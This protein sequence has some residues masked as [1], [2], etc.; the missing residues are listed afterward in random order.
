MTGGLARVLLDTHAFLWALNDAPQLSRRAAEVIDAPG[1]ERIVSV[2][3]LWEIAIKQGIGKLKLPAPFAETLLQQVRDH[4][5]TLLP[6]REAEALAVADLPHHHRDPF[7]R[8][9]V[10]QSQIHDVP[11]VSADPALDAYGIRRIW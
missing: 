1:T 5:I 6:V 8:L 2:A 7:D 4:S 3:T 10:A 11:I 9:L